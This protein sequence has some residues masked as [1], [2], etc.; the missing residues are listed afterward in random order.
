MNDEQETII[1]FPC[2]FPIKAMGLAEKDIGDLVLAIVRKHA[3]DTGAEAISKRESSGGKY[4][5]V[6]ATITAT[7]REQLDN[8]YYELT[9][10][11]HIIM[12]L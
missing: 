3:P 5:S 6:T 1:E 4:I 11:E 12:A 8:I 10:H 2:Q 9:A 7:S